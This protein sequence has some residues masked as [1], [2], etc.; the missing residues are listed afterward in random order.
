[1]IL[2]CRVWLLKMSSF[3]PSALEPKFVA[4]SCVVWGSSRTSRVQEI[5]CQELK[6]LCCPSRNPTAIFNMPHVKSHQTLVQPFRKAPVIVEI[7]LA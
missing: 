6:A 7:T 2:H 5:T 3:K 4:G 1:M